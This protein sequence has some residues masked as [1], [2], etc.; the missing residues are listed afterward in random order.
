MCVLQAAGRFDIRTS[1]ILSN[2]FTLEDFTPSLTIISR[3]VIEVSDI[4]VVNFCKLWQELPLYKTSL[5]SAEDLLDD[6]YEVVIS[7][8]TMM[9]YLVCKVRDD[10]HFC[11]ILVQHRN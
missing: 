5:T 8:F 6:N 9:K 4:S 1:N 11:T 3:K 2:L 7:K 10:A